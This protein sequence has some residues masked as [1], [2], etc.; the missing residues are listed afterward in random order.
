MAAKP[1]GS[2]ARL[3]LKLSHMLVLCSCVISLNSQSLSFLIHKMG[4]MIIPTI[5]VVVRNVSVGKMFETDLG[6]KCNLLLLLVLT[7]TNPT[8]LLRE[9]EIGLFWSGSCAIGT[10]NPPQ[11][12]SPAQPRPAVVWGSRTPLTDTRHLPSS[13]DPDPEKSQLFPTSLLPPT[14]GME[15]FS[16]GQKIDFGAFFDFVRIFI[17]FPN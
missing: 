17:F 6:N 4:M 9:G 2:G 15:S 1:A 14:S 11:P 16:V 12:T 13:A 3:D 8:W 5:V 7:G 10:C